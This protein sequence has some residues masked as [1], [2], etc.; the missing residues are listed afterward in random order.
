ML[1]NVL[2]KG[3][4]FS[5]LTQWDVNKIVNHMNSTPKAVING[6]TPFITAS[7]TLGADALSALR[8]K[9]IPPDEV[10]LTPALIHFNH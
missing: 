3:T 10:N 8:L 4:S 2:P 6:S 9:Q 7:D 5:F 1:R